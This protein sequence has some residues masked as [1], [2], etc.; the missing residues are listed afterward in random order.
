MFLKF[1]SR[2]SQ[3]KYGKSNIDFNQFKFFTYSRD[4]IYKIAQNI[5]LNENDQVLI[6]DY[7]C[8]TVIDTFYEFTKKINFYKINEKL[9]FEEDNIRELITDNTKIIVFI[10]YFG[11]EAKVSTEL[12]IF[13]R[14]NKVIILKDS[15]HSFLTLVKNNFN[16]LYSYDYMVSSI[17]K[18][19]AL[20]VGAISEGNFKNYTNF[21]NRNIFIKRKIINYIK[22]F[23]CFIGCNKNN[24]GIENVIIKNDKFKFLEGINGI[25]DYRKM[26]NNIDYEKLISEQHKIALE[27]YTY[28]KKKSLFSLEDIEKSS[29]QA[30]PIWCDSI[31]ERNIILNFLRIQCIDAYTWPTFHKIA[32]NENLWSHIMLIPLKKEVLQVLRDKK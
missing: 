4:A 16:S 23:L 10:D 30:F 19:L 31:E 13:L 17:Y 27:F 1:I 15:A 25:V 20:H 2:E 8:N 29:L 14:Q 21:I 9:N 6:P 7:V 5:G 32:I 18:N 28:F 22:E 26:I 11:V 3:I 24:R 12:I